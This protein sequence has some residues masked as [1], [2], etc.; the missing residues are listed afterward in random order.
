MYYIVELEMSVE[1][2]DKI[3][4]IIA[5]ENLTLEDYLVRCLSYYTLHPE[6]LERIQKEYNTL[7]ENEKEETKSI[8]VIRIYPVVDGESETEACR[9]A[10]RNEDE[11]HLLLPEISAEEL[12]E[13][14]DDEG[15]PIKYGNPV[16]INCGK[17]KKLVCV[18][19]PLFERMLRLSGRKDEA[20]EVRRISDGRDPK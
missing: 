5:K 12:R 7:P 4:S 13:H 20:D 19:L 6:E 15:F 18:T 16:I 10:I 17:G 1:L 8:R 11:R 3:D 2:K 14:I 9:R